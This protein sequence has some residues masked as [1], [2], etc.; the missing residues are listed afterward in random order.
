MFYVEILASTFLV[1]Y[2]GRGSGLR[3]SGFEC[4][5]DFFY[6]LF[7]LKNRRPR[8]LW[9]LGGLGMIGA[10][11]SFPA[12]RAI[13]ILHFSDPGKYEY[14]VT[15]PLYFG[16]PPALTSKTMPLRARRCSCENCTTF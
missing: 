8:P 16:V 1:H 13:P 2:V 7:L 12:S 6:F 5:L 11:L 3:S 15:I 9:G 14:L 4:S 10:V